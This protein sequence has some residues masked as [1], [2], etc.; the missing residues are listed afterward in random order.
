MNL[1]NADKLKHG[2]LACGPVVPKK[3]WNA[4]KRVVLRQFKPNE[5]TVHTQRLYEDGANGFDGGEY[6]LY[7]DGD[8]EGKAS[9]FCKAVK[10]FAERVLKD[11][12]EE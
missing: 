10:C 4:A 6:F 9:A 8:E 12:G 1:E 11:F 2:I 3:G 7:R 5:Y